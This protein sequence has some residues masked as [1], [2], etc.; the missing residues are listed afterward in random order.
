METERL[1]IRNA[2]PI[3]VYDIF[4]MRNSEFVLRYNAMDTMAYFFLYSIIKIFATSKSVFLST[5]Y[6]FIKNMYGP[7]SILFSIFIF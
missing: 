4:E 1:I 7:S 3:D 5:A 6:P 2:K